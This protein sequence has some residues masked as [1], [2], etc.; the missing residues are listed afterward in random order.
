MKVFLRTLAGVILPV[1]AVF[2]ISYLTAISLVNRAM[3]RYM[4]NDAKSKFELIDELVA[5]NGIGALSRDYMRMLNLEGIGVKLIKPNGEEILNHPPSSTGKVFSFKKLLPSGNVLVVTFPET[6]AMQL[7]KDIDR[8]I[9]VA[10]SLAFALLLGTSIL[11]A[12]RFAVP[13]QKFDYIIS[14]IEKG[15]NIHFPRFRSPHL[16]RVSELLYS[17]YTAMEK[18]KQQIELEREKLN[19]ILEL[20]E[21]GV[22]LLD[23]KLNYL[24]SNSKFNEMFSIKAL[25]DVNF[26][27]QI[28]Q[29]GLLADLSDIIHKRASGNFKIGGRMYKVFFRSVGENLLFVFE[30]AEEKLQYQYFKSELIGNISHELK[31][32]IAALS[33]YA[34]TLLLHQD[35]DSQ[36]REM[37]IKRIHESS[38]RLSEL[39][40]NIIELHTLENAKPEDLRYETVKLSSIVDD[41]KQLYADS[42]KTIRYIVEAENIRMAREHLMSVLTNLISNAI[43]YSNGKRVD[44]IIRKKKSSIIEICVDDEGP[45]IPPAERKRIFERFYTRSKS[46]AKSK[47]GTGLGLSIVKHIAVLYGGSVKL[48]ESPMGGNRFCVE[49]PA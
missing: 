23:G 5:K 16:A 25:K 33:G 26:L 20:I 11:I 2:F 24:H 43:K 34:E 42:P 48:M 17:I 3:E 14:A 27:A 46:R 49:I 13:I 45:P 40:N 1:F 9:T 12:R 21:E 47:S 29:P 30:D 41:L 28:S 36:T 15:Q 8:G 22:L 19:S 38:M 7:K 31:T 35:M 44:V 39:L 32:P 10:V 4:L 18:K 6:D 37:F